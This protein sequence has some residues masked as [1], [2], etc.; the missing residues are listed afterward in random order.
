MAYVACGRLDGF[1]ELRLHPWDVAAG[2]LLVQEAGGRVSD[3]TGGSDYASGDQ[4]VASNGHI[5]DEMLE[6]LRLG[7]VVEIRHR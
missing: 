5:H 2:V 1:W 4:I 7:D 6:V 3:L